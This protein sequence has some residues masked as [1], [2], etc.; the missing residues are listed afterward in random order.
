MVATK[1]GDRPIDRSD[2]NCCYENTHGAVFWAGEVV[3]DYFSQE[4]WVELRGPFPGV[5][6]AHHFMDG[7]NSYECDSCKQHVVEHQDHGG[8]R[9]PLDGFFDH[10]TKI[11]ERL[12]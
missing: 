11:E 10:F 7:F 6:A 9:V 12:V 2:F 1:N 4:T 8:C 3:T 5:M